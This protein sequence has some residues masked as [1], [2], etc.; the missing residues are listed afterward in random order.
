M[1]ITKTAIV[2]ELVPL[3]FV[4]DIQSCVDFYIHKL[5]FSMEMKWEPG[6]K[7]AWC[8]LR[9]DQSAIML[10]Q[11]CAEDGPANQRG[12]GIG[13]Y[14]NCDDV[15]AMYADVLARGLKVDPPKAAHYGE[16]QLSLRDPGE[17]SLIFQSPVGNHQNKQ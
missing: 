5:G 6:G 11:A 12:R 10:Q 8:R 7:L 2:R 13:F 4:D 1:T 9:R 14:F 15:N 16:N 17:Y 3:L